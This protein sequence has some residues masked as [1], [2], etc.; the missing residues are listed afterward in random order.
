[1]K[2]ATTAV[3]NRKVVSHAEWLAARKA[4]LKK[5]KEF[6]RLRDELSKQRRELPWERVEKKYVFDGPTGKESLA[7]LFAGRSQLLVYHFML[8]PDWVEGCP[9]CSF[10]ADHFDGAIPHLNAR[11]VTFL[12]I[13]RAP[14]PQIQAFQKR[15]GWKFKWV[16]SNGTDFNFDYKVSFTPEDIEKGAAN[17]NYDTI[18]F[19]LEE[20]PGLSAFYKEVAGTVYHTYSTFARGL[21][22]NIGAYQFLDL[23]PKGR[24]EEDLAFSMAWVKH[25]DKYTGHDVIDTKRHVSRK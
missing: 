8:G 23:A 19:R 16:S 12:A 14:L 18:P 2:M 6:T 9:S 15:M 24:D 1:M 21:D 25:H 11:D 10:L 3:V 4:F 13:S 7:D 17:Y 20:G 22:M 5:E